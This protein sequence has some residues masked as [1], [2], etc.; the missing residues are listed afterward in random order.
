MFY[1][2][3]VKQLALIQLLPH[4]ETE[5]II[6][7]MRILQNVFYKE[8]QDYKTTKATRVAARFLEYLER[9]G[10]DFEKT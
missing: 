2:S 9:C 6:S 7:Q 4:E 5:I 1:Q 8:M 10:Q 3:C